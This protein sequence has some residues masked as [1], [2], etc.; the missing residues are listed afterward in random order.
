MKRT[1]VDVNIF[2]NNS[3]SRCFVDVASLHVFLDH[4]AIAM[5]NTSRYFCSK[6]IISVCMGT[7]IFRFVIPWLL[8]VGSHT[9]YVISHSD[10]QYWKIPYDN[11]YL[12]NLQK[13]FLILRTVRW[14]VWPLCYWVTVGLIY[15]CHTILFPM[16]SLFWYIYTWLHKLKLHLVVEE[17]NHTINMFLFLSKN[18]WFYFRIYYSNVTFSFLSVCQLVSKC[19]NIYIYIFLPEFWVTR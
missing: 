7:Q 1:C 10:C 4:A 15:I 11:I 16:S 12:L 14:L 8:D 3:G 9:C 19:C 13:L 5:Q 18:S 2:W 17:V 6:S